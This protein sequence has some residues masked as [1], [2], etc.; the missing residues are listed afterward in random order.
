MASLKTEQNR[1]WQEPDVY[2]DRETPQDKSA[3]DQ[4]KPYEWKGSYRRPRR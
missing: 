2:D 4:V 3:I 1:T